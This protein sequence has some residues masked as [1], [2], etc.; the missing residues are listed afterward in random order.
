M[1]PLPFCLFSL[2]GKRSN[3]VFG[4][5][6]ESDYQKIVAPT[7]YDHTL[8]KRAQFTWDGPRLNYNAHVL[9]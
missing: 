4:S 3:L 7:T 9:R 5:R 8:H 1:L 6:W 2:T